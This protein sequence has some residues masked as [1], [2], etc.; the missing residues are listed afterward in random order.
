MGRGYDL[1]FSLVTFL[2]LVA[3]VT[4]QGNRGSSRRGGRTPRVGFYGNRCRN[5][6]SIVSSVVR[7]H[8]RSNPANA[9]GIL[10]MH[11]HDCFVRGCDG[12]ILLAGNTTERNAI[13]NRSLRGFEAIEEAKARLEDACPGTVSCADI[14][15]LA[16]R[17]VVVLTG[18]QGW[19]VPL[20]RL[21]GRISQASDVILPGPFD[22]VDKQKRDFA[23]KTL[24]TLD[25]V[26]LVGG[27]TIGTAGCG[28]VRGRFF[29]FNGTGQPDPSI[30]PSFVPLVQARCPQN[31]DATTRV[32]LDAG[33]AGRFDTS[34][35]RN[36]RS[37]RVVL[38]SDLVLWSDP[39]TRA[40]IERLLGLRFP[41]LRFGSEFARSMIKMSLIEV[42]TGSDGEIR[43]VCSAI[44]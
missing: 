17:D 36:V 16:A 29:N 34:F 32:D 4:A 41:F 26:T 40:I 30:D 8:V 15:T 24:N 10:R 31:G 25:L 5:V 13:P 12:S 23:A 3:A 39:E 38:Q 18:G 11:F 42:K 28:L 37:S 19:R 35:L 6:E 33:S 1:L 22:S 2:V 44:N 14:L 20:G 27:H 21:D 9:P 7:S 43:R